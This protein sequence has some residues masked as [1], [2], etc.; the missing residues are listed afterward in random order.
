MPYRQLIYVGNFDKGYALFDKINGEFMSG[1]DYINIVNTEYDRHFLFKSEKDYLIVDGD[2]KEVPY[3]KDYFWGTLS[4]CPFGLGGVYKESDNKVYLG[5][6]EGKILSKGYENSTLRPPKSAGVTC[7]IFEI[8]QKDEK[9]GGIK[10]GLLSFT[11]E[12][13]VPC[14]DEFIAEFDDIFVLCN[15]V[16]KYGYGLIAYAS[17]EI[18]SS[19]KA[20]FKL[21]ESGLKYIINIPNTV[22]KKS[23]YNTFCGE[24]CSCFNALWM[25]SCSERSIPIV[26]SEDLTEKALKDRLT[27]ILRDIKP[28]E[29]INT[30]AFNHMLKQ[31]ENF[32]DSF[33]NKKFM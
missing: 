14:K 28:I 7:G 30:I 8:K 9:T 16:E 1:F 10:R 19:S 27:I 24:Y 29:D 22:H 18:L 20:V 2:G 21:F 31:M 32:I 26:Y 4:G 15:L 33:I 25:L 6:Y 17:S 3:D 23:F 5:N 11:G 13:I 12:E